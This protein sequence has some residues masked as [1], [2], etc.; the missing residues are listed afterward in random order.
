MESN[1]FCFLPT[2]GRCHC[3]KIQKKEHNSK[4]AIRK[5]KEGVCLFC[6]RLK[7]GHFHVL[8]RYL[9]LNLMLPPLIRLASCRNLV[10]NSMTLR[11][12]FVSSLAQLSSYDV[13][14]SSSDENNTSLVCRPLDKLDKFE[15]IETL[16]KL[17]REPNIGLSFITQLKEFGFKHDVVSYMAIVRFLCHWGMDIRLYSLFMD[18]IDNN[19]GELLSFEISDLCDALIEEIEMEGLEKLIKAIDVLVKVYASVGRFEDAIDTLYK[20]KRGR[21][22]LST[23]TCNYLM[24]QL[25]EW[26][27]L[28]MVESVYRQL[29]MKGLVPNVYTYGILIKGLCRKGCLEEAND[30]FRQMGEAG[31]EPN[32]FTFGTYIDGLCS[33]GKTDHAFQKLKSFRDSNLPVNLF[34]YTSVIR[35]FIKESKLEDV[36]NVLLDMLHTEV[37]PDA[38]CYCV[39]IQGY[40]QKGDILR[41]LDL[42]EEMESRGIKTNCVIVSSIMQ[43]LCG[44]G[45]LVE[46]VAWF[47]DI[48]KSGV[49]LD[50][51]SYNIAID[52]LC[53]LKKMDEAM[54][55]FDD[56]K[57]K[58][59][60]PDVVH[61]TTLIKGYYLNEEPWNAYEIFGEM[62]SNGLKPDFIT[63][64]VLASGLSRFGSFEDTIDLLH[65]MQTQGLEPSS[66][67]HNVIIEGLC[68]GEKTKEAE[69]YFNTLHPKNLDNYAAM[70][71]GY[72]EANNT[73]DAFEI[74]FSERR[75]FAKRA[76]CLKLLSCLCA[77]G[78]TKK[79]MKLY[80][81]FEAS[82]NG[83]C[84]TMYS[85]II[86]LLCRVE[87]MRT[88]RVIFDKM[89]QKGFTP[90]VVTY[91]MMLYGYCR[92][93]WLN[94]AHNLFLDM[95]NRG[96]KPDIY[97][98]T[99]LLHG[100]RTKEDVKDLTDELK[101][102][103]LSFDVN[104]Y[105]VVINKHCQLNNLHEAVL[106]FKEMKDKG[107]EPNTVT[108]TVFARGLCHQGYRNH[109]VA[110]VDEMISKGIQLNKST[111]RALEVVIKKVETFDRHV[112]EEVYI[113]LKGSGKLEEF[114][115]CSSC[116]FYIL[117]PH[118]ICENLGVQNIN[119][120][121]KTIHI[122]KAVYHQDYPD[123]SF[124]NI[125]H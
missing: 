113:V 25:I 32:A 120:L 115:I 81:E 8:L 12:K 43:C 94:E 10:R 83:P 114:N 89:I 98:Y 90:D 27:K 63:F 60:K 19:N 107:V 31:V 29:K 23:R 11:F 108:Y 30:V 14:D 64:D 86:Y 5:P 110:L 84:K 124:G 9:T 55:L 36:E 118:Q 17:N 20:I 46:S 24:N 49:F 16:H 62:K 45:K 51:I 6:K 2:K 93:K 18:V 41:A 7:N 121:S 66:I 85:E 1:S 79:A 21:L 82:D 97:T 106:L 70:M 28:D 4:F 102:N 91:T 119:I 40:C 44:L 54:K 101:E 116:T 57:G 71:N 105:T 100:A 35:G 34:A 3:S 103:G 47:F 73:T 26:D 67:T 125:C 76:S 38:D 15:V 42:Y 78:E 77:E 117:K 22:V 68:K 33:K 111:I 87:D 96:I 112:C 52:A 72:C 74:L 59:M 65:D 104:C 95:K 88:A 61:Y 39:L 122:I 99:V 48:M 123:V 13:S 75:L 92:V 37:F 53:K 56:M 50:E 69:V 80:K 109:A 58:N